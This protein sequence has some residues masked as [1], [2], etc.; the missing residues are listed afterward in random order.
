MNYEHEIQRT[1]KYLEEMAETKLVSEYE[2]AWQDFL[3][4]LER[5]WERAKKQYEGESWFPKLY[6]PYGTLRRKDPLLR[7]LKQA[8]NSE[9]HNFTGS[10]NSP[11]SIRLK[12]K[13]GRPFQLKDLSTSFENGT[14]TL[15][16]NTHDLF[17]E[18]DI[19]FSRNEPQLN[20]IKCRG[21]W[22]NPPTSHLGNRINTNDPI[23]IGKLGLESLK[24]FI[25]ELSEKKNET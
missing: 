7:Y 6:G 23:V 8:R 14:L 13:F 9:T 21:K 25:S 15:S 16:V 10:I 22:Y 1:E 20:R 3:W 17:F 4:R 24:S 5:V 18:P 19:A 12:E 11:L 2:A